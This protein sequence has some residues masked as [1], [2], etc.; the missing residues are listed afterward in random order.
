M[1]DLNYFVLNT[2]QKAYNT[3]AV[4]SKS[5]KNVKCIIIT[6]AVKSIHDDFLQI[7]KIQIQTSTKIDAQFKT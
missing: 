3:S 6:F 5:Y 7:F 4:T 2:C 1:L